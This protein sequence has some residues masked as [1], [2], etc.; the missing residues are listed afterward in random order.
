M[1]AR[2]ITAIATPAGTGGIGIVRIS[3][4]EAKSIADR[5]FESKSGKQ[6][7]DQKGYTALFG[8]VVFQ[9]E[10]IDEA[11]ALI[12][13][14]P[15]SYTGENVCEISCHGGHFVTSAVLR[16][17]LSAGAVM[18]APGE[19]TKRAF[20]NG[21]LSLA[22]TE[23][24]AEMI[25]GESEAEVKAGYMLYS[26]KLTHRVQDLQS[27]LKT[28]LAGIDVSVDYPEE[29][30]EEEKKRILSNLNESRLKDQPKQLEAVAK[31]MLARDLALIQGPPG[32]GKTTVIA[33]I[34][35]QTLSRNPEAKVLI[36]SQTNLAVDN[37]LGR[38]KGKP[39]IRP[40]RIL[41]PSKS[42]SERLNFDE[43]RYL[44][45]QIE[46]WCENPDANNSD[47]GVKL[48]TRRSKTALGGFFPGMMGLGDMSVSFKNNDGTTSSITGGIPFRNT[49]DFFEVDYNYSDSYV[50]AKGLVTF[51]FKDATTGQTHTLTFINGIM[52][53]YF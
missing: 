38:L 27:Q 39:G 47:N 49:P 36:T 4:S 17:V 52:T 42:E 12:F 50:V 20:L 14:A 43:K 25:N 7:K 18:A 29:D 24:V 22:A 15:K 31:S 16:A 44:L 6:I 51:D 5:V 9:G 48:S 23:G 35:W 1:S 32:T 33:E 40:A 19:F 26:E 28:L 2:T 3:G 37:A 46:E 13:C 10:V 11:V 30:I 21:K 53:S 41:P 34:I 45:T 8:S